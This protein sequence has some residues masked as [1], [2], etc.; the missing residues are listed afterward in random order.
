MAKKIKVDSPNVKIEKEGK[1]LKIDIDTKNVDVK[2]VKDELNKEFHLDTKNIDIDIEKSPEGLEVK[3]E[4][5]KGIFTLIANRII[6]FI[7]RR[8]K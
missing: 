4:A 3:V 5:K 1:K 2:I 6:K 8:F 7:L